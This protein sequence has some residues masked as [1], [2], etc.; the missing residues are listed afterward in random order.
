MAGQ[1]FEHH[2]F[3]RVL[4][5]VLD[6]ERRDEELGKFRPVLEENERLR[7]FFNEINAPN[8]ILWV[9]IR[10]CLLFQT[11]WFYILQ[12]VSWCLCVYT[13]I[14]CILITMYTIMSL[15]YFVT[16]EPGDIVEIS[17]YILDPLED[18]CVPNETVELLIIGP[19]RY[20][21]QFVRLLYSIWGF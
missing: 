6:A 11:V 19:I 4:Q 16:R 14:P 9:I 7:K 5:Y 20:I 15:I 3:E 2:F 8:L 1:G 18:M 13:I 21:I 12:T 17:R 10:Q